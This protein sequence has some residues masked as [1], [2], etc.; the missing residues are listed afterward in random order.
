VGRVD[1]SEWITLHGLPVT[2]PSRAAA[3]LLAERENP[4]AVGQLVTDAIRG[5]FDYPATFANA[6]S[7][8]ASQL[9]LRRGD[10]L[11]ALRWLLDLVGDRHAPEW[12]AEADTRSSSV[13]GMA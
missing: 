7:P 4:Q 8:Y 12:L 2:R 11:G 9:G 1:R 5:V 13:G 3:D 10:G 6:L